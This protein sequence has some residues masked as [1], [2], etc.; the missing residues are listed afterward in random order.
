[1]EHFLEGDENPWME[2]L[3]FAS[4]FIPIHRW[5]G[6]VNACEADKLVDFMGMWS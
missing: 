4:E 2:I 6:R 3:V 5:E 1:M